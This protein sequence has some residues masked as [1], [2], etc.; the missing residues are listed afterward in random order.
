ASN[1]KLPQVVRSAGTGLAASH[2]PL[3]WALRSVQ[4]GTDGSRSVAEKDD[5]GVLSWL[6]STAGLLAW[7]AE[8]AGGSACWQAARATV[9][10]SAR[11]RGLRTERLTLGLQAR[12]GRQVEGRPAARRAGHSG[13]R[14]RAGHS[15]KVTPGGSPDLHALVAGA[16]HGVAVLAAEGL[17][18]GRQVGRRRDGTEHAR[19][20]RA[21][22]QLLAQLRLGEGDAP[23]RGPVHE[24]ALVLAVA[25]DHR[26]LEA[27]ALG[28]LHRR[29]G[30]G[31]AAEVGDV[32]AQSEAAVD[33]QAG[34]G[35]V[36]VELLGQL[37][38]ARLELAAV[39]VGPPV[40]HVAGG[41]ELAALVVVAVQHLVADHRADA[42]VVEGVVGVGIEERRLQD[43]GRED[44]LVGGGAVV[45]VH[46][47]RA[48]AP[49]AAVDRLA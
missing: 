43:G 33:V 25:I 48:H 49:F 22:L 14:P 4:A 30:D 27:L 18:E 40:G 24:E 15:P 17:G 39:L 32:L 34:Q 13:P 37:V 29:V 21:D 7:R 1:S 3:T 47:L 19:R 8:S 6:R 2:L 11:V 35:L 46:R 44:D 20:V 28:C 9:T 31:D 5:T 23:D 41:I 45:G 38:G 10:A 12:D 16:N 42:A 36:A 26:I